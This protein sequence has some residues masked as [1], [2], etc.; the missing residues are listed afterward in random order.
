MPIT[1]LTQVQARC[2]E[3]VLQGQDLLA[4]SGTGSG[5]TLAFLISSVERILKQGGPD[6]VKTF[7]IVVLSPVTDLATQIYD[8]AKT[9]LKYHTPLR[10][11]VVIGGTNEKH[12]IKRL[13]NDRIDVLIA[14]PGRLKSLLNQ[15]PEIKSRLAGCQ[16]FVIDEVDKLAEAGF[17][18]ETVFFKTIAKSSQTLAF[19]ATMDRDALMN[20]GLLRKD[21]V[22]VSVDSDKKVTDKNTNVFQSVIVVPASQ[23]FDVLVSIVKDQQAKYASKKKQQSGGTSDVSLD[24]NDHDLSEGTLEALRGWDSPK[25]TG[26]RI[27]IFL[28]SNA[29]I[30][31][32][33][34]AC[35]EYWTDLKIFSL[36]GNLP[37]HQRSKTSESFR[38]TDDC[39]L[40]TSDASARGV[41]YP[42]VTCVVQVGFD[43]RA[44]YLQRVGRTGRAGKSG[45]T[46]MVI[47]PQEIKS[48]D[49]VC[50]LADAVHVS[51]D[52]L[53]KEEMQMCKQVNAGIY[54]FAGA[55]IPISK[56]HKKYAKDAFRGWIGNLASKWKR[57]GMRNE[58]A[59][60]LA[61]DFAMALGL[62]KQDLDRLKQKL[63]MR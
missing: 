38:T 23:T 11:D 15:S 13:R 49:K 57:L 29:F 58:D 9:F 61:N 30:D 46:F 24:P 41:D 16:T 53:S 22:V 2:I 4:K 17:L 12:D 35:R 59:L 36:H 25:L 44:E 8:V 54:E 50:D 31:Y 55:E 42:D 28:P 45:E 43:S 27:M 37:Q 26:Y 47:A 18:K 19:S 52:L 33:A 20:T 6:P 1:Q 62:E 21:A 63:H 10:T 51:K 48:A 56:I 34:K 40:L 3:P 5:K 7:P 60:S 39:I 32:M 14:T